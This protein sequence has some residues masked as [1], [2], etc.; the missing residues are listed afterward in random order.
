M[1]RVASAATDGGEGGV[2]ADWDAECGCEL[3]G[4]VG[5]RRKTSLDEGLK[6]REGL[7]D[8]FEAR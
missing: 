8:A 3:E 6:M 4:R 2:G 1:G 5:E 7:E